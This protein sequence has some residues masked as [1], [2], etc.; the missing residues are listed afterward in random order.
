[1]TA[2]EQCRARA[3]QFHRQIADLIRLAGDNHEHVDALTASYYEELERIYSKQFP[4]A[5]RLAKDFALTA[6]I[7]DP[8]FDHHA[9]LP[10]ASSRATMVA[11]AVSSFVNQSLG[12]KAISKPEAHRSI[13]G[14][15]FFP[16][17][18][19]YMLT[20]YPH[21][22]HP[23]RN[24]AGD[25]LKYI[26][27]A[28]NVLFKEKKP[29]IAAE[30]LADEQF[31]FAVPALSRIRA[32]LPGIDHRKATVRLGG[33]LVIDHPLFSRSDARDLSAWLKKPTVERDSDGRTEVG[34]VR[35]VDIDA[36]YLLLR[37]SGN[38]LASPTRAMLRGIE[39]RKLLPYIGQ[40][41]TAKGWGRS[42][43]FYVDCIKLPD[44][45]T[46]GQ[47]HLF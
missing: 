41:I 14:T 40:R 17:D 20:F 5:E 33:P 32:L 46:I 13:L 34:E 39:T 11:S 45:T 6:K 29:G 8:E 2:L 21:P 27:N 1:M 42:R 15:D 3:R 23:A 31:D 37:P 25:A 24:K 18:D 47:S 10:V 44:G 26:A 43:L 19:G 28:A 16:L 30:K 4:I 9:G 12:W 35:G 36:N 22:T 7:T 38:H